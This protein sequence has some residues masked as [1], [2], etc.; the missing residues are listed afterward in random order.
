MSLQLILLLDDF[1]SC[2]TVAPCSA[3]LKC[4]ECIFI[5]LTYFQCTLGS[6]VFPPLKVFCYTQF[7]PFFL[8]YVALVICLAAAVSMGF[9]MLD[10][11]AL[12]DFISQSTTGLGTRSFQKNA[13]FLHS[14]PF[15]I[16]EQNVFC[17]LSRSL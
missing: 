16:K 5:D 13:T 7:H 6:T 4:C 14:F 12:W 10:V 8:R 2:K 9:L 1:L 15:Y 3:S 17:V 11:F